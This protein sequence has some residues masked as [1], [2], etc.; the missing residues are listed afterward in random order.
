MTNET[1]ATEARNYEDLPTDT[2]DVE[3]TVE[4]FFADMEPLCDAFM[5]IA[6]LDPTEVNLKTGKP[7]WTTRQQ[8]I[9]LKANTAV[10]ELDE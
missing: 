1:T 9:I 10:N 4:A 3:Q 7:R 2:G 5:V 8:A 6:Q